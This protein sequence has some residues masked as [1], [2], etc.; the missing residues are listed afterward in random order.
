MY[1]DYLTQFNKDYPQF[2]ASDGTH[3]LKDTWVLWTHA[4]SNECNDWSIAGYK[5]HA[6]ISTV[7]D[8]WYIFN[9]LKSLLNKDMWFLM[10][11]GISPRWED[12]INKQGGSFKFKVSGD[13]IDNC[14]L[15]LA[16]HLITETMCINEK[17]S[18]LIS[19]I[20]TSPKQ[21]NYSTLSIWNLDSAATDCSQFPS[22]IEGI[23]FK[24]S[25]YQAH[26]E[27]KHG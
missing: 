9:G 8:F 14:W 20:S 15:S 17:D 4:P 23:D 22:N 11:I 25:L 6:E 2:V 10:R 1:Q 3:P 19:G 12:P 21:N 24:M 18:R 13:R 5:K 26:N 16:L 7:E 27:R